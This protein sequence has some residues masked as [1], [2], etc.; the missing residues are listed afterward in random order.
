MVLDPASGP[1]LIEM[2]KAH[3]I[4]VLS[5]MSYDQDQGTELLQALASSDSSFSVVQR[6]AIACVVKDSAHNA[7]ALAGPSTRITSKEQSHLYVHNYLPLSLWVIIMCT[8][9]TFKNKA[10]HVCRFL[11]EILGCRNPGATT[12]RLIVALIHVASNAEPNPV[13]AHKDFIELGIALKHKRDSVSGQQTMM[14]FPKE[15][16]TFISRF[17][18]RYPES[19]PPVPCRVN[20]EHVLERSKKDLIP[21]RNTNAQLTPSKRKSHAMESAG[22]M[23]TEATSQS[24]T[25]DSLKSTLSDFILNRP[26][27]PQ[28]SDDIIPNLKIYHRGE[29]VSTG[30]A[31]L[32]DLTTTPHQEDPVPENSSLAGIK[33]P[34]SVADHQRKMDALKVTT[35]CR[36]YSVLL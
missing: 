26:G 28:T 33:V 24:V 35:T 18:G 14:V 21:I 29:P 2:Q 7:G 30:R 34:G 25:L 6:R 31:A 11:V 17:P 9:E 5:G 13:Q 36:S 12:K 1:Q 22:A 23:D 8:S 27:A 3:L 4:H 10:R 20:V 19:D 32:Q 16:E 15:P